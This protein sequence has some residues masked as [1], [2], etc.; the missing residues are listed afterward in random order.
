M[1]PR[2]RV[3]TRSRWIL[4]ALTV[5]MAA[6]FAATFN[7]Q[8]VLAAESAQA[9]QPVTPFP[10]TDSTDSPLSSVSPN[11]TTES[12]SGPALDSGPLTSLNL[13]GFDPSKAKDLEAA[14]TYVTQDC[15]NAAAL[16]LVGYEYTDYH[17]NGIRDKCRPQYERSFSVA[18]YW[19]LITDFQTNGTIYNLIKSYPK[20]T[21]EF[22]ESLSPAWML[23]AYFKWQEGPYKWKLGACM[24]E[25]H[26]GR[27]LLLTPSLRRGADGFLFQAVTIR[28]IEPEE[29]D[30]IY[31]HQVNCNN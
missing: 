10:A 22:E 31:E 29:M 28:L 18:I 7:S 16:I 21:D 2:R 6:S 8:P 24:Y 20:Y 12:P 11:S 19:R 23:M 13:Q 3:R 9:I 15:I 4:V 5:L 14:H 1:K 26:D 25:H 27:L 30:T 17:D